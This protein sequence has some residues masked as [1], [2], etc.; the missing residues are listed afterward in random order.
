MTVFIFLNR[1][2]ILHDSSQILAMKLAAF[3]KEIAEIRDWYSSEHMNY[4]LIDG[5]R[6]KW[7]VWNTTLE[8]SRDSVRQIQTYLDR[9]AE[10]EH[11][12]TKHHAHAFLA[13]LSRRLT[14]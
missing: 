5:E 14:R 1:D 7:W 10:G 2:K 6:S 13:H 8:Y 12:I 9:I 3:N 4:K 11:N